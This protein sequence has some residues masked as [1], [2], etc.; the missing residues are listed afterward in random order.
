M[1]GEGTG[2]FNCPAK[3]RK[4][5]IPCPVSVSCS[6]VSWKTD[7]WNTCVLLNRE[8]ANF[9]SGFGY[10]VNGVFNNTNNITAFS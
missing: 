7:E 1:Y 5:Q 6:V 2:E 4:E 10:F 9:G 3:I 8:S